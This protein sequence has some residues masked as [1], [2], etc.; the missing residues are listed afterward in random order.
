VS[1]RPEGAG[2]RSTPRTLQPAEMKAMAVSSP[3][4]LD[5]PVTIAT[6]QEQCQISINTGG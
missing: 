3:I 5:T 4:P 6:W 1:W 2:E